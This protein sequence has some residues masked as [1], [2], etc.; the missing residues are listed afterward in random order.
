M[1][2]IKLEEQRIK[3]SI[4]FKKYNVN[5]TISLHF[6]RGDYK[7]LQ[8]HYILL[9]YNERK[10]FA[11]SKHEYIIEQVQ[12]SIFTTNTPSINKIKF[13]F[14]NPTKMMMW[15]A[16]L[17]DKVNKKQYYNYTLDDYYIDIN[18]Y[19]SLIEDVNIIDAPIINLI[20]I[21]AHGKYNDFNFK[22]YILN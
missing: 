18:K 4:I 2:L 10:K 13:N 12:Y 11:E 3:T 17:Q 16:R 15:I 7:S 21:N 20:A 14:K 6:R 22:P 19:T 5:N 9:D 8:E 1:K